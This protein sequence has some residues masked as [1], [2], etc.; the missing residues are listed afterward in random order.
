MPLREE[1]NYVEI[2]RDRESVLVETSTERFDRQAFAR[3]VVDLVRP[4]KTTVAICEGI[5]RVHI[6]AGR[7]WG[8]APGERWAVLSV[9]PE[10]SKR[11]I[12]MAVSQLVR[13]PAAYALDVLMSETAA[14]SAA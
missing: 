11:A 12:A 13:A 4:E 8:R 5:A 6:E 1:Q 2:A 14:S 10:A 7:A 3:W 9:P